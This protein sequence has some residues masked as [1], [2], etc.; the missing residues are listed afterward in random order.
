[1]RH[2]AIPAETKEPEVTNA[3]LYGYLIGWAVTS[4]GLAITGRHESRPMSVAVVAG[5]VW[6]LLLLGAVQFVAIAL[7][8]EGSRVREPGPKS[9]DDELEELL[10]EWAISDA[11]TY[12]QTVAPLD[13]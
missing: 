1:V 4:I 2:E 7:V 10:T 8:A 11:A 3:V 5:T 12:R 9:I 6:P 13:N